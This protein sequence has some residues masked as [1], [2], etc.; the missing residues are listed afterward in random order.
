MVLLAAGGTVLL[1]LKANTDLLEPKPKEPPKFP[2]LIEAV[3]FGDLEKVKELL[4][5]GA[6]INVQD[7]HGWTPLMAAISTAQFSSIE[8]ENPI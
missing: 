5:S 2:E 3:W 4:A 8:P 6:D 7:H 1:V